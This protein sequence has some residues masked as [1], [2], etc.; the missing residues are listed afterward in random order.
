MD[1]YFIEPVFTKEGFPTSFDVDSQS[2]SG[3][4]VT[5]E[6]HIHDKIEILYCLK[7]AL[8]I[9]LNGEKNYFEQG[10]MV[11]INSNEIHKI[12]GDSDG[13]NDYI[14]VKIEPEMLY[15]SSQAIFEMKYV[16]PFT[17]KKSAYPQVFKRGVIA[18][19]DLPRL[20]RQI[21][22]ENRKKFFGYEL[23]IRAC[24]CELFLWILRYWYSLGLDLNES[25]D[26]TSNHIDILKHAFEFVEQH[27]SENISA[28]DTAVYCNVSYSYFS[29]MFKKHMGRSFTEYLNHYRVSAAESLL[30]TTNKNITEIALETGFSDCG[31]FIKVFKQQKGIS[32]RKFK[33][34]YVKSKA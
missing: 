2:Y 23:A 25:F 3:R 18:D 4:V 7:G 27:F 20:F 32:P 10:D 21:D 31:Y 8:V 9:Y 33:N 12:I 5:A 19:T 24:V 34:I 26:I 13:K 29:R 22:E 14:V 11:L 6:A 15:D 16:L 1:N 28:S 30:T 17:L